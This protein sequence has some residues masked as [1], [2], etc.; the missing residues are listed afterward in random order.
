MA[1]VQITLPDALAQE[2]MTAGLLAPERLERLLRDR[3]RADRIERMQAVRGQLAA[4]PLAPMTTDEISAEISAH[5][6]E[7]RRACDPAPMAQLAGDVLVYARAAQASFPKCGAEQ[8]SADSFALRNE[9]N[10]PL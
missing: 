7:Q 10:R 5:R 4:E 3:L 1:T 2:A 6:S 9:W 8:L